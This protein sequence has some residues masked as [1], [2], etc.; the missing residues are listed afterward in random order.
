[1]DTHPTNLESSLSPAGRAAAYLPDKS[2][3]QMEKAG[4]IV[5]WLCF[6]PVQGGFF[7]LPTMVLGI[8][9]LTRNRMHPGLMFLILGPIANAVT[10]LAFFVIF[11]AG[12]FGAAASQAG[13]FR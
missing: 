7:S 3:Q 11:V 12:I 10:T 8:I 5:F 2:T 1:M 9:L 13:S 4:W 6:I